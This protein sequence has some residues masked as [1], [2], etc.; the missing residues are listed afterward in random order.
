M[1]SIV[2]IPV[3]RAIEPQH[4]KGVSV[5]RFFAEVLAQNDV[6]PCDGDILVVSSKVASFFEGRQIRLD[7]VRASRKARVLGK[8]YGK[9]PRKVELILRE[10]RV[11]FVIPLSRI[12]GI[13]KMWDMMAARSVN[14]DAMRHGFGKTNRAAFVVRNYGAY[15]D[16]AGIDYTNSPDGY[17]SLLPL[18]PCATAARIRAGLRE[19]FGA[20]VAVIITDTLTMVGRVGSQDQAIGYAGMDPITRVTFSDDLFGVPRS[21]GIDIAVDSIAGMAGL[22]MGQ[23]TEL[24]PAVL[25]RGLDHAAERTDEA[26]SGMDALSYPRGVETKITALTVLATIGFRLANLLTFQRW[27]RRGDD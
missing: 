2:P 4:T 26:L 18:D 5:G 25:V 7:T 20:D 1:I 11:L 13:R 22:V 6:V 24:T 14:P 8:L 21:G 23:T 27:P 12:M 17:V 19:A 10:G 3:E 16:D 9:D 15:L